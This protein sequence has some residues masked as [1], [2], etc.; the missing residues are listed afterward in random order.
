MAREVS[1][2]TCD[3]IVIGSDMG[4]MATATTLSRM[5]HKLLFP[6]RASA[7]GDLTLQM[8]G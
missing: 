8:W 7:V 3:V 1:E 2:G 5:S 6:E 4:G